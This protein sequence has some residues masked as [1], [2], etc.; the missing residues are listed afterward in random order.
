M[1]SLDKDG[2]T[3]NALGGQAQSARRTEPKYSLSKVGRENQQSVY[4][5]EDHNRTQRLG[6]QSPIGGPIYQQGSTLGGAS[7]SFGGG[8]KKS[9]P[10]TRPKTGDMLPKADDPFDLPTNDAMGCSPDSQPFKY[11]R[12]PKHIIG[13]E[14]RGGLKDAA[15]LENHSVAFYGRQSPGPAA[16]PGDK[17]GRPSNNLTKARFAPARPFGMK[18]PIRWMELGQNPPDVGPGKHERQDNSLGKQ[19]RSSRRTQSVHEFAHCPKFPKQQDNDSISVLDN[20]RSC[21]GKQVLNKNRSSPAINF[22]ADNRE[23]KAKTMICMTRADA[24]PK[25]NMPKFSAPMPRLPPERM[26]M[27][28]GIG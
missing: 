20:A 5:T 15:L 7:Y 21:M 10:T 18:T 22:S 19:H 16:A 12:E 24:G 4:I 27:S 23:T 17:F 28:G 9:S 8:Q 25:A 14:P 3:V 2:F 26:I 11:R 1:T 6:R 13:T